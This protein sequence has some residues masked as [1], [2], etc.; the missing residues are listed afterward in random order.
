M[1][2]ENIFFIQYA[3]AT[4]FHFDNTMNPFYMLNTLINVNVCVPKSKPCR[5]DAETFTLYYGGQ[6]Q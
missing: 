3:T 4:S 1:D 6:S 2:S 5:H